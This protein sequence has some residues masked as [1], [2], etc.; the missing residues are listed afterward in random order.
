MSALET[1]RLPQETVEI[2]LDDIPVGEGRAVALGDEQ[3][4]VFRLRAADGEIVVRAV[5]A[6]CPH[7]G[8]PIADGQ[9]DAGKVVC[10]LHLHTYD[11]SDGHSLTGQPA[12]KVYPVEIADG[13]IVVTPA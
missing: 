6:V 11:L 3:V 2:A 7:L 9:T 10:P 4:A 1:V 13:K 5:S 8:G 12:L